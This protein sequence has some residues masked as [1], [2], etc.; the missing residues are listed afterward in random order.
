MP[1]NSTK[2]NQT[3]E[4]QTKPLLSTESLQ[5]NFLQTSTVNFYY[6]IKFVKLKLKNY[7]QK[8]YIIDEFNRE[9]EVEEVLLN[10][11]HVGLGFSISGGKDRDPEPDFYIRVI[12]ISPGGAVALDGRILVGDIILRVNNVDCVNVNHQVAVSALQKAGPFVCL[13]IY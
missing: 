9:W 11:S 4:K 3:I 8:N 2:T 12:E 1:I 6:L 5:N 7:F 10:A 13:V